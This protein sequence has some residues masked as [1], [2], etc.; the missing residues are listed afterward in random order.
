VT[1]DVGQ[2]ADFL[3]AISATNSIG[4]DVMLSLL[5]FNILLLYTFYTLT[6]SLCA[7]SLTVKNLGSQINE[8]QILKRDKDLQIR[9]GL[10]PQ[11][12]LQQLRSHVDDGLAYFNALIAGQQA[13]VQ[14]KFQ[15][16]T[17][18]LHYILA[19]SYVY[20]NNAR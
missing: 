14:L 17:Y 7:V 8:A 13:G 1:R 9:R 11:H 15:Q 6:L 19:M 5:H 2:A 10:Y 4:M 12:G 20:R 16:T 3:G 18:C